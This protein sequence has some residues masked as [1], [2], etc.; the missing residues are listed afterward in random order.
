MSLKLFTLKKSQVAITVEKSRKK[1]LRP[2]YA[3][4]NI[5][6]SIFELCKGCG[7]V[8][9]SATSSLMHVWLDASIDNKRMKTRAKTTFHHLFSPQIWKI[10]KLIFAVS[11]ANDHNFIMVPSKFNIGSIDWP[12]SPFVQCPTAKFPL[13][14][15]LACCRVEIS[16][17][18][19]CNIDPMAP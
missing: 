7:V 3:S 14:Y 17:V 12:I 9:T 16:M 6:H 10:N 5:L 15:M 1:H 2:T 19:S 8:H 11:M 4:H 13:L 18:Y